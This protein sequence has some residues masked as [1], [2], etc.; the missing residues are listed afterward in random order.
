MSFLHNFRT[1][2]KQILYF[3][4]ETADRFVSSL[5]GGEWFCL[6]FNTVQTETY[7]IMPL[8]SELCIEVKILNVI[9][10]YKH[11]QLNRAVG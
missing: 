7:Y 3:K 6:R 2:H 10:N 4:T 1:W 11:A 8:V 5:K 9:V